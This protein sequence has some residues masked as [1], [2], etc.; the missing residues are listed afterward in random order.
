MSDNCVV[1]GEDTNQYYHK[2]GEAFSFDTGVPF[3][4]EHLPIGY[5]KF[6]YQNKAQLEITGN[7]WGGE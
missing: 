2:A 3:C 6:R 5:Q 4:G 1:C 7:I